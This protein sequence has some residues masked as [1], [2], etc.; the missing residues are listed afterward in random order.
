MKRELLFR[1]KRID[2]KEMVY[3][4]LVRIGEKCF[5]LPYEEV[6]DESPFTKVY[7]KI[8]EK[9]FEVDPATVGQFIGVLDKTKTQIFEDDI[10]ELRYKADIPIVTG[11]VKWAEIHTHFSLFTEKGGPYSLS[12][13]GSMVE[14]IYVIGNIHDK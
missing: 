9:Y 7:W 12:M 3:G 1:G 8:I 10:C 6:S 14:G 5:I 4:S 11:I 13:G 2:N